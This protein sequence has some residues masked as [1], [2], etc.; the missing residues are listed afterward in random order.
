M[1]FLEHGWLCLSAYCCGV[2]A[3]PV[4]QVLVAIL[5]L[6]EDT[7]GLLDASRLRM[8]PAGASLVNCGRAEVVVQEDVLALLDAGHLG[9]AVLDV[10]SPEPP[11]PGSPLWHHPRVR[12]SPHIAGRMTT[13]ASCGVLLENWRA[14]RRGEPPRHP[15]QP[16]DL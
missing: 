1:R 9:E 16:G 13:A 15:V 4:A 3:L 12:L 8:L 14:A 11:P 7:R 2:S 6:K 10:T 5:P